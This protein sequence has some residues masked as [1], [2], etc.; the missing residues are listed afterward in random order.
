MKEMLYKLLYIFIVKQRNCLEAVLTYVFRKT[1]VDESV[2][3]IHDFKNIF[4]LNS[5]HRKFLIL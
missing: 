2:D 1:V 3:V 5:Q 4:M